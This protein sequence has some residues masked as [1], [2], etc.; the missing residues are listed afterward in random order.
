MLDH[1]SPCKDPQVIAV[2]PSA[3]PG[4]RLRLPADAVQED[5]LKPGV[6]VLVSA[7]ADNWS[8]ARAAS[9]ESRLAEVL[10]FLVE[11]HVQAG[12]RGLLVSGIVRVLAR[13]GQLIRCDGGEEAAHH[14]ES[15]RPDIQHRRGEQCVR[16][17]RP[18][19][20]PPAL[21]LRP[22]GCGVRIVARGAA[23]AAPLG[24]RGGPAGRAGHHGADVEAPAHRRG[25]AGQG[26]PSRRGLIRCGHQQRGG[27]VAGAI[28][29]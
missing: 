23:A 20:P 6:F 22:V 13:R 24:R 21:R 28:G 19:M 4:F 27:A 1:W 2:S 9:R 12:T 16:V 26:Q 3:M 29:R 18:G 7:T 15:A 10:P 17:R 25:R 5:S 11:D 8:R 14:R